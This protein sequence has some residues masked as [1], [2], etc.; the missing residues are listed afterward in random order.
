MRK[1]LERFVG[2][3]LGRVR[4]GTAPRNPEREEGPRVA[5]MVPGDYGLCEAC[6]ARIVALMTTSGWTTHCPWCPTLYA[7]REASAPNHFTIYANSEREAIEV[8]TR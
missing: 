4:R 7:P 3:M 6:G 2:W 1:L 8:L 5:D